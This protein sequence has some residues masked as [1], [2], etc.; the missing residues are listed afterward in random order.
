M[1]DRHRETEWRQKRLCCF[2]AFL[3]LFSFLRYIL[4]VAGKQLALT[5][6]LTYLHYGQPWKSGT[7]DVVDGNENKETETETDTE[8][9]RDRDIHRQRQREPSTLLSSSL[10]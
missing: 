2:F 5:N 3:S 9:Q 8:T 10:G 7:D 1:R 6:R 4:S